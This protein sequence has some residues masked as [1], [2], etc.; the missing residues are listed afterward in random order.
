MTRSLGAYPALRKASYSH[1]VAKRAKK[2]QEKGEA[3]KD[4]TGMENK[5]GI[6]R[7]FYYGR[8]APNIF[9]GAYLHVYIFI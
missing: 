7:G 8:G 6:P 2:T 5:V 4:R 9:F 3:H 1:K